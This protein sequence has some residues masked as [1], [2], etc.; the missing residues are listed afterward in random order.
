VSDDGQ[1]SLPRA[2]R[3]YDLLVVGAGATGL[4]AARSARAAG[5]RV[6]LV[7]TA[8]PGGD[9]THYG[10]VPSKTLLDVAHRVSRARDGRRFGVGEVGP[11]DFPAVMAHVRAV[12]AEVEQ[13]ESPELLATE[14]IDLLRG[15]ATFT[16]PRPDGLLDVDVDGTR[17]VARRVV[18]ATGAHAALPPVPGLVEAD[19]LTNK[20]V[21]EL[22]EQPAHLLVMGGGPIGV[23]LAQA[24]RGLGSAVTVVQS[25]DRLLVKE[26]P[27]VS[28]LLAEVLRRQGVDVRTGT[29]VT[30]VATTSGGPVL[31]LSDGTQ[32]AGS[33]L[34][35]AAGRKPATSGM[36]LE[37][38]GVE[39]GPGGRVVTD[40]YLR[41]TAPG[42]LAAG[43]CTTRL[44]LTHVGDVQGR[45]A[46]ANAF[47][48]SV[49]LPALLG[50][51]TA[52][53]D[54]VV[55]W[56]T[57]TDPEVGRV[58]LSEGEAHAR[59]GSRARVA[60]VTMA[61][62]DRS[63]TSDD[64]DGYVK[65]VVAPRRA[66]APKV[67]DRVVG[68]TAVCPHGGELAGTA[69]L[70]MQT[71]MLAARIAQTVAPYPTYSLALRI[72]AARLFGTYAGRTWRP[73]RPDAERAG[74]VDA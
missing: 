40:E 65:L 57:F 17:V 66:G 28:A 11:V 33:H 64:R 60:V 29:R 70:A 7:E 19:P 63:R 26:E 68:M 73:A 31:T 42:I 30:A 20:T 69:A 46:A 34:L 12:V 27:E 15:W 3:P 52:F 8:R 24:F 74:D 2:D 72:A 48:R 9:C 45:L 58:G 43:D 39:I 47:A 21:F 37:R 38:A 22:V 23:E 54:R 18:L 59:W 44:Q 41:T 49:R 36:G 10:C 16:D 25:A 14:G 53:D 35:V 13:D 56:V 55:P 51:L 6:A 4:G 62:T 71:S 5:R 50:G 67:L 1:V 61:E 32:V